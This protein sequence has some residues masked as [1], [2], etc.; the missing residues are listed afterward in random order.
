MAERLVHSLGPKDC[1]LNDEEG[2]T[3]SPLCVDF[4]DAIARAVDTQFCAA[5]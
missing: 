5:T 4:F 1:E 3:C 2:T